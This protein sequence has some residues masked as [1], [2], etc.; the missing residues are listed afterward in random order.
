MYA[1]VV[2]SHSLAPP[3]ARDSMMD[4]DPPPL[5]SSSSTSYAPSVPQV[6]PTGPRR[7]GHQALRGGRGG[8]GMRPGPPVGLSARVQPTGVQANGQG[9]GGGGSLLD[10]VNGGAGAKKVGN[11]NGQTQGKSLSLVERMGQV[12]SAQGQGQGKKG[13]QGGK[14][15]GNG[16]GGAGGSLLDRLK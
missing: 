14:M 1:D 7:G 12:G 4:L 13:T 16:K 11:V 10:R 5:S 9:G 2:E 6:A 3:P 15:G 8:A